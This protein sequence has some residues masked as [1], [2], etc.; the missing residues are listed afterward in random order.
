MMGSTR[1]SRNSKERSRQPPYDGSRDI[2]TT[3]PFPKAPRTLMRRTIG[4]TIA[5][6]LVAFLPASQANAQVSYGRDSL[7]YGGYQPSMSYYNGPG[8][9]QMYTDPSNAFYANGTAL[10]PRGVAPYGQP[11]AGTF[12][13]G[14]GLPTVYNRPVQGPQASAR[15]ATVANPNAKFRRPAGRRL[16]RR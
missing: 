5:A 4:L 3:P 8:Y 1:L 7:M 15:P 12:G 9:T 14:S 10:S 6:G 2:I 13:Q 16:F 11:A